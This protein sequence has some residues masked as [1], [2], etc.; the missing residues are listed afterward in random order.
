MSKIIQPFGLGEV[1][2]YVAGGFVV[3]L[4]TGSILQTIWAYNKLVCV[5]VGALMLVTGFCLIRVV[6]SLYEK[7]KSVREL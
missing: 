6:W 5:A 4:Y 2:L 7:D 1:I 3:F